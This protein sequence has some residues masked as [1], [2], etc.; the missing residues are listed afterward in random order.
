MNFIYPEFL[1]ALTAISVPIVIHLFNFRRFKKVYFSDIRFLKN[2]EIET[3]SRSQ[4]KNLLI[5]LSRILAIACLVAAFAQPVIPVSNVA[6]SAA[7]ASVVVYI[8][9]SF[10]MTAQGERGTLLEEAVAKALEVGSVY[11]NSGNIRL[12]TNDFSP[13]HSRE[14]SWEEF[15]GEVTRIA[16]SPQ[17]RTLSEVVTRAESSVA[18]GKGLNLFAITDLQRSTTDVTENTIDSL[19]TIYVIPIEAEVA[20][21]LFIDSCW[22]NDPVRLPQQPDLLMAR[23]RNGSDQELEDVSVTL[24]VNG[25]QRAVGTAT[26]Q[27]R[28]YED[29]ELAFTNDAVGMQL[30]EVSLT[31]YPITYDDH[32]Y[33]SYGLAQTIR[34]LNVSGDDGSNAIVNLFADEPSIRL[35]TVS[36]SNVDFA[37]LQQTDLLICNGI[38]KFPSGMVSEFMRFAN[39]GGDVLVIPSKNQDIATL[40]ELL[41]ALNAEQLSTLDT[42]KLKVEGVNLQSQLYKNVFVGWEERIDLPTVSRHYSTVS[43]TRSS[44]E[45]LLT[46]SNGE[47]LLSSY[48]TNGGHVYTLTATLNDEWTNF[49]RH[50][51][52]VPTLFNM[53]LNSVSND[54]SSESIGSDELIA[55]SEELKDQEVLELRPVDSEG[56]FVPEVIKQ[57]DATGI[58]VHGQVKEDG[59]Y[60]LMNGPD[61]VRSVSF[62]YDRAESELDFLTADELVEQASENGIDNVSIVDG[63]VDTIASTVSELHEGRKLWKLFLFLAL[64][65]LLIETL[66]IRLL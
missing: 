50:A 7:N 32:Y 15:K 64:G 35:T 18:S 34:I 43:A 45:Q 31:D 23:I 17:V 2:V 24:T 39:A 62:N 63:S 66:L 56:G 28:T 6:S 58:R 49:H 5:L 4:L 8:D 59:H 42:A 33:L 29:V 9:N 54:L 37:M 26:I 38:R 65:F 27:P 12:L 10:S 52:F 1:F 60:L 3:R 48:S 47:P 36:A 22:F 11:A 61:T 19:T 14:L 57:S 46:L 44:R 55:F 51:I 16:P 30:A 20:A 41:L 13:E 40:N 25:R 21:N 53:A